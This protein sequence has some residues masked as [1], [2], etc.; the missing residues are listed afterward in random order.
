MEILH[1]ISKFDTTKKL[2]VANDIALD[3][4]NYYSELKGKVSRTNCQEF[5]AIQDEY[6]NTPLSIRQTLRERGDYALNNGYNG[7]HIVCESTGVYSDLLLQT[8][9]QLGHTTAY[10]NGKVVHKA[11][12]IEN[13]DNSKDDVKDARVIYMLCMMGKEQ[14]HRTLPPE[15]QALREL[16]KL[17]SNADDDCVRAKNKISPVLKKLFC[18]FPMENSFIYSP[19][20]YALYDEY[21]LNPWKITSDSYNK[22]AGKIRARLGK[23]KNFIYEKSLKKIYKAA[24]ES[25]LHLIPL[26]TLTVIEESYGFLLDDYKRATNRKVLLKKQF[27]DIYKKLVKTETVIPL[28]D[29]KI[30]MFNIARFLGETGPLSDFNSIKE[31]EKYA[32]LN[33]RTRESGKFKGKL[34]LSKK[35][36]APLREILGEMVFGSIKHGRIFGEYYHKRKEE[37]HIPG[38]QLI[39]ILERKLLKFLFGMAK[40]REIFNNDKMINCETQYNKVA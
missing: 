35:G 32:G 22:F 40:N 30:K 1:G 38:S 36:R 17:Y 34:K 9:H 29:E 24:K 15:Y 16:N 2:V 27:E 8:A 20:G 10:V 7:L 11:K 5:L 33:L 28:A 13:N 14:Y 26:N 18:S 21:Q 37:E 3:K 31:L 6:E 12:V 25:S 19:S 23:T 39:A 4:I